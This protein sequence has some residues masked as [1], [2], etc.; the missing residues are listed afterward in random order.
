MQAFIQCG[1][2]GEK[3]EAG[4]KENIDAAVK[5]NCMSK[6]ILNIHDGRG[7]IVETHGICICHSCAWAIAFGAIKVKKASKSSIY[8]SHIYLPGA[9]TG[10]TVVAIKKESE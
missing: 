10:K 1:L 4:M 6:A 5:R 9:W 8:S 2:C 7:N 3:F